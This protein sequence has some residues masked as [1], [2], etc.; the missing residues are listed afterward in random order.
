M[1]ALRLSLAVVLLAAACDS[2][3]EDGTTGG[4]DPTNPSG[5]SGGA[6]GAPGSSGTSGSGSSGS[7]GGSSGSSGSSSGSTEPPPVPYQ[8]FDINHVLSTGQ[9]NSVANGGTPVL[10][11]DQPYGNL[12]FDT[13]VMPGQ[14][15]D[16]SGCRAYGAPTA[17]VP[18]VEG[19]RFFSYPVETMSSGL[20]NEITKLGLEKFLVG[21]PR[22]DVLVTLHGRSGNTYFCLRKGGCDFKG[23]AQGYIPPFKEG[24]MEVTDAKALAAAAGKTYVVRAVTMIHGESDHYSYSTNTAEFPLASTHGGPQ[25]ANYGDG[26]L[27]LQEDYETEV[28][29]ITGQTVPI[30]LLMLQMSNWNDVAHS[31]IP[32]WQLEAHVRAPGKVVVVAPGYAIGYASDCLHFT[33][34]GERRIGEYFAKAYARIVMEGRPWEPLRPKAVTIAGNVITAKF[35]VPKPPLVL[36]TTKVV[37]PGNYGFEFVDGSAAPPAITSVAVT[38]PDTVTITLASAPTGADKRLQYAARATPQTCPGTEQGPR[39]NLRDSDDTPSQYGYD[40]SN[41][42]VHFDEPVK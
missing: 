27:E 42:A 26:M 5:S 19:D 29:K 15:C 4:T 22:H 1:K 13:G 32:T 41:W 30:P 11:A 23:E 3:N 28:K 35:I 24:M 16:G 37:N 36:D 21:K 6:S 2:N 40:L 34:H 10:T 9:S 14:S 8:A 38:A 39:G 7:S 12:A 25:V 33:N 31:K 18:L 20:A 17:L